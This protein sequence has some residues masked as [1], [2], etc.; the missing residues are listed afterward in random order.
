MW[1]QCGGGEMSFFNVLQLCLEKVYYSVIYLERTEGMV[2]LELGR[3]FEGS[4]YTFEW[5]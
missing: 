2:N 4:G 3:V 5:N 1:E